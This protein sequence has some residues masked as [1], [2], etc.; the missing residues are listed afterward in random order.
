MGY[1]EILQE[2][3]HGPLNER[4]RNVVERLITNTKRLLNLV[5]DLLDRARLEAGRLKLVSAPFTPDALLEELLSMTGQLA[6]DKKVDF[7]T[8]VAPEVPQSILGDSQRLLQVLANLV[9]NAIKFTDNGSITVKIDRP[10]RVH[11]SLQVIDTGAGI[12]LDEQPYV[13]DMFRQVDSLTTR[14]HS[15][16]GLGLSIVKQLVTLMGGEVQLVSSVGTGTTVTISL[17]LNL[18]AEGIRER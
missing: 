9:T 4:Q 12:P 18:T 17:P 2:Q 6:K 3:V 15:G 10:D 14:K 7:I 8:H 1:G 11:W 13:F 16:A 5:N